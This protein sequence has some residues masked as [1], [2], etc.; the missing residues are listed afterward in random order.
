MRHLAE[1]LTLADLA[2]H[3]NMSVRTFSRRFRD[4]AG[5][6]PGQWLARQRVDLARHFLE[7]TDW[8]VDLVAHR[9]GFGTGTSLRQHLHTALGVSPQ[10]YRRTFRHRQ[11]AA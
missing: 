3:A 8:P 6:T 11:A 7:T 2:A 10:A 1:P 4:E 5:S 9:A